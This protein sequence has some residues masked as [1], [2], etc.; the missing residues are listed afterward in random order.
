M[1][2]GRCRSL[3]VWN[4][5]RLFLSSVE[6]RVQDSLPYRSVVRTWALY[7]ALLVWVVSLLNC[8]TGMHE[9]THARNKH[10]HFHIHTHAY[11]HTHTLTHT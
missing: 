9:L 1:I 3:R 6:Q 5:L 2:P 10:T 4:V 8:A 7:T 11:T